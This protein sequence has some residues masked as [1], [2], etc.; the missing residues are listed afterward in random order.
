MLITLHHLES[1]LTTPLDRHDIFEGRSCISEFVARLSLVMESDF[2]WNEASPSLILYVDSKNLLIRF[3][4]QSVGSSNTDVLDLPCLLV[5][6]TGTSQSRQHDNATY[7][8]S[9]DDIAV[10]SCFFDIQLTNL[11]PRESKANPHPLI[12]LSFFGDNLNHRNALGMERDCQHGLYTA[13]GVGSRV[14]EMI[15]ARERS[16]FA[17]EKVWGD[18]PVVTGFWGG[19]DGFRRSGKSHQHLLLKMAKDRCRLSFEEPLPRP[20]LL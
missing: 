16:G 12:S 1:L 5:L 14:D 15:L 20:S 13:G 7:S 6:I 8:A 3:P 18:I 11:S 2:S 4:A 19:K 17:G 9:A 10:Q